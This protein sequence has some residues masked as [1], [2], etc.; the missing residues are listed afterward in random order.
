MSDTGALQLTALCHPGEGW[1]PIDK[2]SMAVV[3]RGVVVA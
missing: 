1:V 2:Y 3:G